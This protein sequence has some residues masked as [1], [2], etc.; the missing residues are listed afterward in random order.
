MSS[1]IRIFVSL[2]ALLASIQ[3]GAQTVGQQVSSVEAMIAHFQQA[4][5]RHLKLIQELE[6]GAVVMVKMEEWSDPMPMRTSDIRDW[7]IGMAIAADA[8]SAKPDVTKAE[9]RGRD[10]ASRFIGATALK[11]LTRDTI[12][13]LNKEL[14]QIR[15][16]RQKAQTRLASLR[17]AMKGTLG[18]FTGTWYS[19]VGRYGYRHD[20]T[21]SQSGDHVTGTWTHASGT[22]T[23]DGTVRDR[24]LKFKWTATGADGGSDQGTGT[25]EIN[26]ENN[27]FSGT[28]SSDAKNGV[29]NNGWRGHKL[30]G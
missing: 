26:R 24:T 17:Q 28:Y 1:R 21:L 4:E 13:R 27:S 14:S 29:K 11:R 20:L 5:A 22:G 2:A 6:R 8:G 23:I 15:S 9:Q 30:K 12:V 10:L 3:A 25:W 7:A 19:S 16:S 18:D